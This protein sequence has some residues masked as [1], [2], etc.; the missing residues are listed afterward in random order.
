[1]TPMQEKILTFYGIFDIIFGGF[2]CQNMSTIESARSKI[3][4]G[5]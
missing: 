5:F 3:S 2:Y 4:D 1:M